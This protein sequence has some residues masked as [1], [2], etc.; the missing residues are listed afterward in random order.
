MLDISGGGHLVT[1][2][3]VCGIFMTSFFWP[4]LTSFY[5]CYCSYR[6]RKTIIA[7]SKILFKNIDNTW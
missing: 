2:A 6:L 1:N 3:A 7:G 5:L 4:P